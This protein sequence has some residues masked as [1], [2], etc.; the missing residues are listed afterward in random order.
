MCRGA[1]WDED[2]LARQPRET[3]SAVDREFECERDLSLYLWHALLILKLFS[4]HLA[5]LS[6]LKTV[7]RYSK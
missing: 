5:A 3:S 4:N 2:E 6:V 1:A 7:S